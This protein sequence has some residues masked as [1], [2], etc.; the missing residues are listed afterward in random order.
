MKKMIL[1]S[2][3]AVAFIAIAGYGVNKSMNSYAG[4]N[5]LALKNVIALANIENPDSGEEG[6]D[7]GCKAY[8]NSAIKE[9][10]PSGGYMWT[11][12]VRC[13]NGIGFNCKYGTQIQY[14]DSQG[15]LIGYEDYRTSVN[16]I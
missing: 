15:V 11:L 12:N 14:F 6:S 9:N 3:F 5:E 4:L 16:C 7:D 10:L 2:I 1:S 8:T 13:T